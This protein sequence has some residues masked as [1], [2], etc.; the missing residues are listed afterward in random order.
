MIATATP[1]DT[2]T[3]IKRVSVTNRLGVTRDFNILVE[4]ELYVASNGEPIMLEKGIANDRTEEGK[5]ILDAHRQAQQPQKEPAP[6]PGDKVE[7]TGEVIYHESDLYMNTTTHFAII[8]DEAGASWKLNTTAQFGTHVKG[9]RDQLGWAKGNTLTLTATIKKAGEYR[10]AAS[11][12]ITRP[13]LH[14]FALGAR[15]LEER[16]KLI[17]ARDSHPCM[18]HKVDELHEEY[19]VSDDRNDVHMKLMKFEDHERFYCPTHRT[20]TFEYPLTG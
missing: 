1:F 17:K 3:T 13:R 11:Y 10:G 8:K 16:A 15:A 7:I 2:Y 20:K 14:S 5:A 18:A 19:A 12:T 6:Q 9:F 4:V